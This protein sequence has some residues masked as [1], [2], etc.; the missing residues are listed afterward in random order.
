MV[1]GAGIVVGL[2]AAITI[3][4]IIGSSKCCLCPETGQPQ[5][6]RHAPCLTCGD[7]AGWTGSVDSLIRS[8]AQLE[9]WKTAAML[10]TLVSPQSPQPAS[11]A[12]RQPT[13]RTSLVIGLIAGTVLGSV[14][15]GNRPRQ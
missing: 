8:T 15:R 10:D 1:L 3:A 4:I 13:P 7:V 11:G 2:I 5:L 12:R 14:A 6:H 9:A